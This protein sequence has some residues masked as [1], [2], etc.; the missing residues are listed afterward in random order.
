MTREMIIENDNLSDNDTHPFGNQP[1]DTL[2]PLVVDFAASKALERFHENRRRQRGLF[3]GVLSTMLVVFGSISSIFVD[4]IIDRIVEG[5][6]E[7]S[8]DQSLGDTR[9][10]ME[11]AHLALTVDKIELKLES[12][13]GI[14]REDLSLMRDEVNDMIQTYMRDPGISPKALRVRSRGIE[15]ILAKLI[16]VSAETGQNGFV[17]RFYSMAPDIL[18]DSNSVTQT[19]AQNFG[20]RLIGNPGAPKAWREGSGYSEEYQDY[21]IFIDRAN[22]TGYPELYLAYELVIRHMEG[23]SKDEL[24]PLLDDARTLTLS[25]REQF[26]RLI[27]AQATGTFASKKTAFIE[28]VTNRFSAFFEEYKHELEEIVESLNSLN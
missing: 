20:Q 25:D 15:P 18:E 21:K 6:V 8:I 9:F 13:I 27:V 22:S 16:E 11:L 12:K 1:S 3:I 5:R 10:R 4:Q 17:D 2:I 23:Q 24:R 7:Q 14:T 19:M 26:V 28:R